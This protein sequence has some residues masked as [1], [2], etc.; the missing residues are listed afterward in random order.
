MKKLSS[1]LNIIQG[2]SC[3][4]NIDPFSFALV[5]TSYHQTSHFSPIWNSRSRRSSSR[6]YD[7]TG[8]YVILTSCQ[9]VLHKMKLLVPT[10]T[11]ILIFCIFRIIG[12]V[13]EAAVV[14]NR[15]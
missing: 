10:I 5:P 15:E 9:L 6:H 11:K 3:E 14:G 4:Q 7:N 13:L 12:V 8:T 1:F 2:N